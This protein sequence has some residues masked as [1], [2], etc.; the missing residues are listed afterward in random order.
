MTKCTFLSSASTTVIQSSPLWNLQF[1]ADREPSCMFRVYSDWTEEVVGKQWL[2]L[3]PNRW[4]KLK[5][6]TAFR[7][8]HSDWSRPASS[9][10]TGELTW[11]GMSGQ[12]PSCRAH[13]RDLLQRPS[14]FILHLNAILHIT[15]LREKGSPFS[16]IESF[17]FASIICIE[18][19][20]WKLEEE[21]KSRYRRFL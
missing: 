14:F 18:R 2:S 4:A 13:S 21:K 5:G 19:K 8:V 7:P 6:L 17:I 15:L 16:Q 10:P 11:V 12:I 1:Y 9:Y 20:S 3:W